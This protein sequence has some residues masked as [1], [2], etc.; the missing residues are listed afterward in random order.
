MTA[1]AQI[2]ADEMDLSLEQIRVEMGDTEVTPN[3]GVTAGS[4]SL[5]TSGN[6]I[7]YTAAEARK[8]LLSIAYEQLEAPMERLDVS[9]GIIR[10]PDTGRSTTYWDLLGGKR[11]GVNISGAAHPKNPDTYQ[12]I[13]KPAQRLDLVVK[14]T[15]DPIFVQDLELPGMV[16]GRVVRP[17][18]YG[19][20]LISV[21]QDNVSQMPGVLKV[22]RDGSFL[23]VAAE[24]E[25]EAIKAFERLKELASWEDGPNLPE[26]DTFLDTIIDQDYES[27]LVVDGN[28]VEGPIPPIAETED[29]DITLSATYTRPYHMHASLGPSAS[30]AQM[31][32]GKLTVWAHSQGV[33]SLKSSIAH[34]LGLDEDDVHVK[35]IEGPGCYGHTGADDAAFDAALLARSLPGRP[36]STKWT[37]PD[38]KKWEPY[39][40][41]MVITIQASLNS[42]GDVVDWNHA[43]FSPPHLGRT[44]PDAQTSGLLASWYLS[45]PMKKQKLAPGMWKESG[46][47]RNA[48]PLYNFPQRRIVK[49]S[50]RHS[51]LR[52]SSL[53][54]LGAFAN[55]F[56]IE[57]FMDEL[58]R[59]AE[60]D[61][62]E[63]RLRNLTDN[64]AIE[65]LEAVAEKLGWGDE[66]VR[67][68]DHGRGIA[69]AQYKNRACYAAVIVE[70]SVDR[71]DGQIS[72]ER[73]VI[74]ADA[75]QIVNPDGLSNQLEGGFIQAASMTLCEEVQFDRHGVTSDD[76]ESYPI[77]RFTNAPLIETVLLDRPGMPFLGTGEGTFGPTP[78]AIANAIFDAVG[79]RMRK[80]PFRPE[81][82]LQA[83]RSG[84]QTQD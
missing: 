9:Q 81:N 69:L 65:V 79:V 39:G 41:A 10:D 57:S 72:L 19:A 22:V 3:E 50:L 54:S 7:R 52:V 76:W 27:I 64:R 78:A 45:K 83:L 48:N 34:V 13:G 84:D 31:M 60:M 55:I 5:E 8:F 15:G 11:F 51:P 42:D 61:P 80:M 30:V 66:W 53:R 75:G 56:A 28:P 38:E 2:M 12:V 47:H 70:L 43:V 58:A 32:D 29:I 36:I 46:A 73:A 6:A 82:I 17:P 44:R 33:F 67:K 20:R 14:V 59:Q 37:L 24:G 77:L 23:A 63:F 25:N 21:D 26:K 68:N 49:H 74:A 1:F 71:K 16:H 4:M 40:P 18:N 62:L 35:Y